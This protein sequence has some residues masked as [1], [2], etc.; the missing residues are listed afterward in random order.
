MGYKEY[1]KNIREYYP[2]NSLYGIQ[3]SPVYIGI[4]FLLSIP[5]MGYIAPNGDIQ[6]MITTFNSLY[7]IHKAVLGFFKTNYYFFQFPLWDT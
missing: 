5:F 7:G 2:F 6:H 3:I 4:Y 1:Y